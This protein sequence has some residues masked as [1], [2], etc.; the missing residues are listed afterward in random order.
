MAKE[1]ESPVTVADFAA[2]AV[3]IHH[4]LQ[5]QPDVRVVGEEVSFTRPARHPTHPQH[6]PNTVLLQ[7]ADSLRGDGE[8][9][10]TLR[11]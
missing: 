3:V 6:H 1:D 10:S 4:L 11:R 2:Q 7:D 5:W 8:Q 9:A